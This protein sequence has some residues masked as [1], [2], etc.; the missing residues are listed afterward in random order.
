M[1]S[2][3]SH[4]SKVPLILRPKGIYIEAYT[5]ASFGTHHDKRSHSGIICT[6]G[7]AP[8]Y[9]SSKRQKFNAKSA[10]ESEMNT[11]AESGTMVSYGQQ[12][13]QHQGY[14][15]DLPPA[16]LWEDNEATIKNIQ[17]GNS[18]AT[19]SRHYEI[20][21]FY[22]SDLSKRGIVVVRHL[23]T[24]EMTAD[25]LTKGK[26]GAEHDYLTFKL[27]NSFSDVAWEIEN[28]KGY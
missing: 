15:A 4:T 17:R 10:A 26:V 20:K 24:K 19:N 7:G 18:S 21:Q 28:E 3:A 27:M 1:L 13:L 6:L 2:F 5:D 8:Y 9:C 12:Y 16:T 14:R 25:L 23:G 22:I 11:T